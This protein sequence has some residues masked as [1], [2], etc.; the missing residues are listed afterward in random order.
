MTTVTTGLLA[1]AL[2][3]EVVQEQFEIVRPTLNGLLAI[4]SMGAPVQSGDINQIKWLNMSVDAD[5]LTTVGT[6]ASGAGTITVTDGSKARTG[7]ALEF[8]G[9]Y[10]LVVSVSGNDLTVLRGQGGTSAVEIPDGS[11]MSIESNA[12]E[13]NSLAATDGIYS[14]EK[15]ENYFQTMDTAVE[16]AEDA[17]MELQYGDYNNLSFQTNERIRQLSIQMNKMLMRGRK[18]KVSLGGKDHY[19]SGGLDYFLDQAEAISVDAGGA[20]LTDLKTIGDLQMTVKK[21]GGTVNTLVCGIDLGRKIQ[22]L[23]N[24]KYSSQRLSDFVADN[25]GLVSL[26]SDMPLIG[27]VVRIVI[28]TNCR[29]NT[30]YLCDSS[31]L[32]VVPKGQ[33]NSSATGAWRT[34]DATQPGQD[35]QKVRVLGKFACEIRDANTHFAKLHNIGQVIYEI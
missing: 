9:E 24:A 16:F 29:S 17:L 23:V 18:M 28:D 21:R 22:E 27:D 25:G 35:G 30:L 3:A 11:V 10:V 4:A 2:T 12:R 31:R 6:A 32:R 26:P 5:S 33:G 34:L 7:M 1:T 8:E 20:G 13:E 19:Y 15:V 14:P